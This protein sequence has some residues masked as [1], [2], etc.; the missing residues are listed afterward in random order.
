VQLAKNVFK[1]SKVIAIAG[2]DEKCKW[3]KKIGADVALCVAIHAHNS[4][5]YSDYYVYLG[6]TN[7]LR[8]IVLSQQLPNPHSWT[9]ISTTSAGI[10]SILALR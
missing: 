2:S 8:S 7:P 3:L 6:T 1:A 5:F 10:S 4:E 9:V